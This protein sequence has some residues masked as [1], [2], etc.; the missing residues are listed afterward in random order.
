MISA[1]WFPV[2]FSH[3]SLFTRWFLA[4]LTFYRIWHKDSVYLVEH[5]PTVWGFGLTWKFEWTKCCGHLQASGSTERNNLEDTTMLL[6]EASSSVLNIPQCQHPPAL[7]SSSTPASSSE[8]VSSTSL[9]IRTITYQGSGLGVRTWS[10]AEDEKHCQGSANR[11]H[12]GA[13]PESHV[14]D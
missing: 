4:V 1:V 3:V 8:P 9:S 7:T 12:K 2:D 6:S 11:K 14:Q 5:H 10:H 13:N